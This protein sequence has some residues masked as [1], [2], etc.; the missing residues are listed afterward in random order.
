MGGRTLPHKTLPINSN[1]NSKMSKVNYEP[2][3]K[4][5]VL[6]SSVYEDGT[7]L[8]LGAA[9]HL[10]LIEGS[11]KKFAALEIMMAKD[12]DG[13]NLVLNTQDCEDG[14]YSVFAIS[15]LKSK[16]VYATEAI[17]SQKRLSSGMSIS[18]IM[19]LEAGKEYRLT[20]TIDGFKKPFGWVDG[21]ELIQNNSYRLEAVAVDS[22]SQ[23]TTKNK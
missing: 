21:E 23:P 10:A 22:V 14:K 15:C 19:S 4:T 6:S 7:I 1:K 16:R 20:K 11:D 13:N 9:T 8:T 2:V 17:T 12:K 18:E 3:I 5:G